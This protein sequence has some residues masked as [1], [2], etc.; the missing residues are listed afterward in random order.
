M[1]TTNEIIDKLFYR[2]DLVKNEMRQW[3]YIDVPL[4]KYAKVGKRRIKLQHRHNI[5]CALITHLIF[6]K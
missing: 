1:Q 2:A 3:S 5:L 4:D 6:S